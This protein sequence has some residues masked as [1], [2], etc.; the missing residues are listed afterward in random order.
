MK[1]QLRNLWPAGHLDAAMSQRHM[2]RVIFTSTYEALERGIPLPETL[3]VT[4][5]VGS[6]VAIITVGFS[7]AVTTMGSSV[8]TTTVGSSVATTTVGSSVAVTTVA[9]SRRRASKRLMSN[10]RR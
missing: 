5:N 8:A 10:N 2:Q 9:P 7:A 1:W 6:S 3:S 4:A